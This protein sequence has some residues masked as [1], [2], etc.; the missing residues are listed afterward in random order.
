MKE[1]RK[2]KTM[3]GNK[4]QKRIGTL[5][6]SATLALSSVFGNSVPV[7]NAK[8]TFTMTNKVTVGAGETFRLSLKGS[9]KGIRFSSNN[10]KVVTVSKK[11]KIKAYKKGTAVITAKVK[12]KKKT[13]KVV[14]KAAANG[15]KIENG[16]LQLAIN[17]VEP[18]AVSFTSGYSKSI[19]FR[20][21][22]TSIA[23]VSKKGLVSAKRAG[24]TTITATT[25]NGKKATVSCIVK[26]A[27]NSVSIGTATPNPTTTGTVPTA[28]TPAGVTATPTIEP[29]K[30]VTVNGTKT[31]EVTEEPKE[32]TKA[33]EV[34]EE[35]KEP[36]KA[37]EVTEEPKEPTKTPEVTEEPKEPTKTPEV[38]E[39]PKEP[40]KTPE[41]AEETVEPTKTPVATEETEQTAEPTETPLVFNVVTTS[42]VISKIEDG[43]IYVNENRIVL[44]LTDNVTYWKQK[45]DNTDKVYQIAKEDLYPGDVILI[46]YSGLISETYPVSH[47]GK[48][49]GI[50]VLKSEHVTEIP[51]VVTTS[52]VIN[53]IKDGT[54]YINQGATALELTDCIV[55]QREYNGTAYEIVQSELFP[56]DEVVITYNGSITKTYPINT[57][58]ECEGILVTKSEHAFIPEVSSGDCEPECIEYRNE[59]T[60]E[61]YY[62]VVDENTLCMKQNGEQL[63][64]S[65]S[66]VFKNYRDYMWFGETAR[67]TFHC[68]QDMVTGKFEYIVDTIVIVEP[69]RDP[70]AT[71]MPLKPVI[72]LYPEETT[73]ISVD[74][75]VD[76]GFSYTYPYSEE[77]P[78]D[79]IAQPDGTLTN[80]AD[81]LEYSYIFWEGNG[82]DFE[83]D[84]SEGFC[85]KGEDITTFFQNV[86][87]KMG[88]TPKEY[89]EF[90]VYWAPLL[91]KNPYNLISFQGENYEDMARLTFS[92]TPDSILRVYMAVKPL[93]TPVEIEEQTFETFEREGFTV[94]EWGGGF[95]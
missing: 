54:I 37:P 19:T 38:T 2:E 12:T 41:V 31:P 25:F 32:P 33:P 10:K 50:L 1:I 34:T 88:L 42:A 14:V 80:K 75:D 69:I 44:D 82:N 9:T 46:G 65:M 60:D 95:Y 57:M 94:V 92:K 62:L 63:E 26:Q 27:K 79:V 43:N 47:M 15:I 86:L 91:Q 56:G 87:P 6:L 61:V 3:K 53:K 55:Y 78:W 45:E 36:T 28:T 51:E 83:P 93:D 16:N 76:G 23:T 39:E 84:F 29:T 85:V 21:G 72:Y 24:T 71:A 22:N 30:D 58:L 8:D 5:I 59:E 77:G 70:N 48:C 17:E 89:N 66:T 40:T 7:S 4:Q 90:I 35:P 81:G 49:Q 13:C 74:L 20:S 73:E 11:G 68:V 67:V 64:Y 18:L 52:A